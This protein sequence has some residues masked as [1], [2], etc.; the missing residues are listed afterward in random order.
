LVFSEPA[1]GLRLRY[2]P[3]GVDKSGIAADRE[4]AE[5]EEAL[6]RNAHEA[7][8]RL[9]MAEG[10]R[11]G[12]ERND[13][14]K[15]HPDIVT[16][17]ELPESEKQLDRQSVREVI[18]TLLAM[19]YAIQP[20][21]RNAVSSTKLL[22]GG[23]KKSAS[24]F[25]Q[26][27]ESGDDLKS[28]QRLW[29][30]HDPHQW[31][32][33]SEIFALLSER[34]LRLSEPLFAHDILAEGIRFHP[35]SLALRRLLGLAL[36]RSGATV[37][38]HDLLRSLYEQGYRD[39][40][41]VGLLARTHKDL[42]RETA[43]AS[44]A[45]YHLRRALE[46]YLQASQATDAY[47]SV[48]NA[49]TLARILGDRELSIV[50]AREA[51]QRCRKRL[52]QGS[53]TNS[54]RYWVLSTLGEA[55]LLLEDWPE[56]ED[57]YGQAM[58]LGRGNWGSLQ[59]THRN[60]QLLVQYLGG[61]RTRLER[62]FSFPNVVVFV[63]HMIDR[64]D[65]ESPR[66]PIQIE[67]AVK[68]SLRQRL[69]ALNAGFGYASAACGSDILFHEIMLERNAESRVILP[70]EKELFVKDCVN[71]VPRGDWTE[72][73]EAV[74]ARAVEVQQVSKQ[75]EAHSVAYEFANLI[76]HGLASIRSEQL[77]TRLIPLAVWDGNS[78]EELGGTAGTAQR[79]RRLGLKIEIIDLKRI[80]YSECP[81][82]A[83]HVSA[84]TEPESARLKVSRTKS[85]SEIRALLFAD[86]EGFSKLSDEE[87]P[88]FV[89]HYLGLAG[90]LTAES[91]H[92]P[93]MKNTWGDGLY[94]VF[95]TVQDA[96]EFALELRD[97]VV[98]TD[99]QK[100]GLPSVNVRIALHAGPVHSCVD[101]VTGRT[102][103]MGAHVNWTARLE[104]IT[105]TGHVYA[106]QSFAAL[107]AEQGV[108]EFR[109]DYVG[110]TSLAKSY[111]M[112]PTYVVRRPSSYQEPGIASTASNKRTCQ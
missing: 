75:C 5:L 82:L 43:D 101:P 66:F 64:P 9:R 80:L 79:W 30:A 55:A 89:E 94:F 88:R 56:A 91:T 8:A 24:P 100:L 19:G 10:W 92:K 70:Y 28:L 31:S 111:G 44:K 23:E 33:S 109:C 32:G 3:E 2:E 52:N 47:W 73:F 104:P 112:F 61:D 22:V 96:G 21:L 83:T 78:N 97:R 51:T 48:I 39:E 72:R 85:S 84:S 59:S 6:A 103:Y 86:A 81:N 74:L 16:F 58:E 7:W 60:A 57:W 71:V 38:A 42:A 25:E 46:L 1:E 14:Q 68:E 53:Q 95:L 13:M 106:S 90:R 50:L 11:Y 108:R 37:S 77:G 93:L 36:A 110:Q 34:A 40:E 20:P 54:D 98:G 102:N 87:V 35:T 99:W 18:K 63:G 49:A 17:E 67:L 4:I 62:I 29:G 76:L 41:T 26:L 15:E 12:R 69:E 45:D 105:P 107:A 27:K 65:R